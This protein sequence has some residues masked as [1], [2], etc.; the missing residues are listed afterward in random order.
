MGEKNQQ[1]LKGFQIR[2]NFKSYYNISEF[3]QGCHDI[4]LNH[5]RRKDIN[6][7]ITQL[8]GV[9]CVSHEVLNL[10]IIHLCL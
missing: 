8:N 4:Q 3:L 10:C 6:N 7:N 2:E 9:S 1:N 5:T